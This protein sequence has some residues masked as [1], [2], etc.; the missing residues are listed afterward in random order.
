MGVVGARLGS[1]PVLIADYLLLAGVGASEQVPGQDLE[2]RLPALVDL[3]V[4]QKRSHVPLLGLAS[5][6]IS[7]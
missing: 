2:L 7:H 3:D 5:I 4:S 6:L 1:P